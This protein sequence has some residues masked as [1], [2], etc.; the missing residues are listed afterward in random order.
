MSTFRIAHSRVV[1]SPLAQIAALVAA[2]AASFIVKD[3]TLQILAFIAIAAIFTLSLNLLTGLAGQI[4]LGHAGLMGT[5]AYVSGILS[6]KGL[7]IAVSIPLAAVGASVASYLLSFPAGRVREVYLAMMTLGFGMIFYEVVRE[8][9]DVTGGMMGLS[10]IPNAGLSTARFLGIS[11]DLRSYFYVVLV[12]LGLVTLFVDNVAKSRVG[13]AFLAL[14]H[15]EIAAGS[16]GIR[17]GATRRLAY[18]LSGLIAGIA[19][20]LYAHLVG[21]IGPDSFGIARS[22]EVLVMAIFGGLASIPGQI[23]SAGFFTLLPEYLNIFAQYQTIVYGLILTFSLVLMPKGLGGL[24]FLAPRYIR[25]NLLS[26]ARTLTP[27]SIPRYEREQIAPIIVTDVV[28]RFGGLVALNGVSIE[29]QPGTITALV[30]P[31]GSGKS[32]LVNVIGGVY[33][34]QEGR[35]RFGNL[36]LTRMSDAEIAQAGI[37]RTFQDPR[38]VPQFTVRENIVLGAQRRFRSSL[39]SC[40]LGLPASRREEVQFLA[41]LDGILELTELTDVADQPIDSLPYGVRRLADVGR[42]LFTHPKV[43]LLDEPAAG[44]SEVEMKRL[45]ALIFRLK[46]LGLTI[47]LIEHHIDF[48]DDLVDRVVVFDEG[49]IIYQGS[50]KDMRCDPE[51]IAAYLGS[52]EGSEVVH[53]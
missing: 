27:G 18:V 4:S 33:R 41:E 31:N 51:V 49:R 50:I 29:L 20:A 21:Y 26:R 40:L 7:D 8:W 44:L 23:L 38:L 48:L 25:P 15:G 11:L 36:D 39:V 16:L 14:Q 5:A 42:A 32:T 53:A 3:G 30:G 22:I 45:A 19:G 46:S 2:V 43:I 28:M 37:V 35:V 10:G 13:R 24:L 9:N 52:P 1:Q 12:S 6:Q 34:P 17:R 47:L